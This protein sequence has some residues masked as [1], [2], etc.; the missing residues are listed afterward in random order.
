M[1]M[2]SRRDRRWWSAAP[3]GAAEL[4][5]RR[6]VYHSPLRQAVSSSSDPLQQL[7]RHMLR[8]GVARPRRSGWRCR[9]G[10]SAPITRSRPRSPAWSRL[11]RSS[12]STVCAFLVTTI[13]PGRLAGKLRQFAGDAHQMAHVLPPRARSVVV[14]VAVGGAVTTT[15]PA[16]P[17]V[18]AHA[19]RSALAGGRLASGQASGRALAPSD[20]S[21]SSS[22]RQQI[23]VIGGADQQPVSGLGLRHLG[24]LARCHSMVSNRSFITRL[25]SSRSARPRCPSA[26]PRTVS[27]TFRARRAGRGRP[28][29]PAGRCGHPGVAVAGVRVGP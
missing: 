11:G 3:R 7:P 10:C 4:G 15:T 20:F 25:A 5:H 23:R 14:R 13:Q 19:S 8:L 29:L 1:R 24:Q 27:S 22:R 17:S 2:P 26:V 9:C 6:A 21:A 18:R 28:R 16:N 12:G